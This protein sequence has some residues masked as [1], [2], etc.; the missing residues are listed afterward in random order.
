MDEQW[1]QIVIDGVEWNYEV[2]SYGRVRNIKTG[3][4]LKQYIDRDGYLRLELKH[5][6]KGK[7][8]GVHRLVALMFIENND[9]TKTQVNHIDENKKNN[10]V[11][12]LEWV[13]PKENM[14]H[15]TRNQRAGEILS[16]RNLKLVRCIETG[17]VF[18]SLKQ[19]SEYLG[20]NKSA[21]CSCLKGRTK[22]CGN[23]HWEYI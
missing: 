11:D 1:K 23:L 14:N 7:G 6:K 10:M 12:N 21:L 2:S 8:F 18:E 22:T 5:N 20:V 13:T 9:D 19:A 15:G 16:K 17:Q 4:V 3:R